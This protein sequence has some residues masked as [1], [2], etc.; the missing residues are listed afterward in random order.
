METV[1]VTDLRAYLAGSWRVER[2]LLDR[3][4]GVRGRFQGTVLFEPADGGEDAGAGGTDAGAGA[5]GPTSQTSTAKVLRQRE[6]GTI[7]WP[8]HTGTATREYLLHATTEPAVLD[9]Y[10]PDER[11]FHTLNLSTGRWTTGHGCHPDTYNVTY[12]AVSSMRLDYEWDVSG[13]AKDLLLST[14]LFRLAEQLS[15]PASQAW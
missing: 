9:M 13:P 8:T 6:H 15:A 10:F 12:R 5:G 7:S 11:F 4:T 1:S 3:S 14:S 2:T